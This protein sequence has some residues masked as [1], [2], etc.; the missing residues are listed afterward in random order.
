MYIFRCYT[1]FYVD[2]VTGATCY[3]SFMVDLAPRLN[4]K[5]NRF[6]LLVDLVLLLGDK[7]IKFY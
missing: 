6:I 4:D 3:C 5:G 2:N 7:G 1:N